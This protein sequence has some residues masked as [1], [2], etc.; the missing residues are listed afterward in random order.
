VPPLPGFFIIGAQKSGTSTL[1]HLLQQHPQAYLC[2]PKEP[3]FFSDPSIGAKGE[4]WYRSLFAAAGDAIAVGEASTTYSMYP[5]YSGVVERVTSLVAEPK[6]IYLLREPI[7]RMRSAYLHAL[8]WGSETRSIAQALTEDPRY[9]LSTSYAMQAEQWLAA[10]PRDALLLL[11]LEELESDPTAVLSRACS[12]LG[13]DNTWRPAQAVATVMNPSEGKRPPRAWWR[14]IG[15]LALR[16]GNTHRVPDWMVRL[17]EG[18]SALVR[19]EV[20]AA[21]LVLPPSVVAQLHRALRVDSARL[22]KLWGGAGRPSWLEDE[23]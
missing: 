17:N 6:L 22:A 16:T 21:E 3:H 5:H 4:D 18:D 9:L 19:R 20:A 1:H 14:T 10:V 7:A 2:D 12:F 11:S 13:I 8:T 15:D 23:S